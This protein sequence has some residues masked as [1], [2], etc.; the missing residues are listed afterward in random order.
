M[1]ICVEGC[2]GVGKTTLVQQCAHLLRCHAV[3]EEAER[4]PF[5][6]DFYHAR[7]RKQLAEH[8]QYTFLFLQDW[9]LRQAQAL[10]QQGGLV[11]CDFHPLKSLVFGQVILPPDRREPLRQHYAALSI[12]QPDLLVYVKANEETILSRVRKRSDPYRD[13]I[14]ITYIAQVLGAYEAFL[15]TYPGAYLTIDN[16]HLDDVRSPQDV[17][18]PLRQI[19]EYLH[20]GLSSRPSAAGPKA[21]SMTEPPTRGIILIISVATARRVFR[22]CKDKG[23]RKMIG[24]QCIRFRWN[25]NPARRL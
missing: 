25:G 5:L 2:L 7:D 20:A 13:Q 10:A 11:L 15:R 19:Q 9:Q 8:V 23:K 18:V 17:Q 4:N 22:A 21:R 6:D 16:S 1:L 3:Y 24:V 14:D 12:P